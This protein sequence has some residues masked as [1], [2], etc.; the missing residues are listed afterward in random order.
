MPGLPSKP[1]L[2]LAVRLA[3]EA[4]TDRVIERLEKLGYEYRGDAGSEGGL[5]FVL[6]TEPL[7]R[8]A[9]VHVVRHGDEQWEAYLRFRHL[10]RT[11]PDVRSAYADLKRRLAD[12][13][14]SDRR[15][16]SAAKDS[17][18]AGVLGRS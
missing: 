12:E 3:A 7:H 4:A 17:F 14:R 16:Y 13:F 6:E 2:D 11:D 9:H 1:I 15:A 10:L 5:V 18:I 8:I